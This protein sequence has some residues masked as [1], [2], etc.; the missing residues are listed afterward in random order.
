MRTALLILS[1]LWFTGCDQASTRPVDAS[2]ASPFPDTLTTP[3]AHVVSAEKTVDV[4]KILAER[5]VCRS[6]AIYRQNNWL[7]VSNDVANR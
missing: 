6:K 1:A 5:D 4:T 2:I 7:I 3:L